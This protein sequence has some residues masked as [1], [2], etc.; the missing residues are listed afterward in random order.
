MCIEGA[1]GGPPGSLPPLLRAVCGRLTCSML[2]G[3]LWGVNL[4]NLILSVHLDLKEDPENTMEYY[5]T[6]R[7]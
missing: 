2:P 6:L 7:N 1:W 3:A 5:C 4:N